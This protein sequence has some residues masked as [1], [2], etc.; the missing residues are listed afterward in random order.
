[1]ASESARPAYAQRPIARE[2]SD[3]GRFS[4]DA[5]VTVARLIAAGGGLGYAPKA[6]GT[7]ASAAAALVG[8]LLLWF[9][10]NFLPL[11][12]F[13]AILLG[14]WAIRGAGPVGDPGWIVIDEIAGMWVGLLALT[15]PTIWGLGACFLLFRFLDIT[16]LGPV[17]WA[18]RQR[19]PFAVMGDDLV[20]GLL[21][22]CIVWLV[23]QRHPW[24]LG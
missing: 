23:G 15:R 17:G 4:P 5:D 12:A 1:M 6:P 22:A 13:L 10:P 20:A 14:L 19:G 2:T 3:D 9:A 21:T 18:D 7:V 11:A 8:A 16:K 24:L